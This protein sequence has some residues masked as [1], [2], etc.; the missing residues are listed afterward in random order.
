MLVNTEL[1][2]ERKAKLF[3]NESEYMRVPRVHVVKL[4]V[5]TCRGA[6]MRMSPTR[7]NTVLP[8]GTVFSSFPLIDCTITQNKNICFS[9]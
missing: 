3:K 1:P 9:N 4:K 7:I 5:H 2:F 6:S 8:L